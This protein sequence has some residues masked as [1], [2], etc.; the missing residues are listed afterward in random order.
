MEN[1]EQ[2][3]TRGFV[4]KHMI[5]FGLPLLAANLM[6]YLYQATDMIVVGQTMGNAGVVAISNASMIAFV[7]GSIAIGLSGGGTV[8]I[9]RCK[10]AGDP[11]GQ[12]SAS[13]ALFVICLIA[14]AVVALFGIAFAAPL[15]EALRV[16]A[17][18][19]ADA[20]AYMAI[21]C[22]GAIFTF[23]YNASCA[24]MKGLGD[25]RGPFAFMAIA[26]VV[27]VALDVVFVVGLRWGVA[28]VA[29]ATVIAQSLSCVL[30]AAY[31]V[32]RYP[33]A[34]PSFRGQ[35]LLRKSFARVLEVGLPSTFQMAIVNVSY[36]LVTGMLNVYG[37]DV[38][39]A[40][41]VGLK[42]STF[43]GLPCWAI[44]QAVTA[45]ASQNSGAKNG[46]RMR[47]VVRSGLALSISVIVSIQ[48]LIQ[49]FASDFAVL[50]GATGAEAVE[51]A[52]LYLRI[53]C[54]INGVF[55][56][57]MYCFDSFALGS[58]AP[59]LAFVN[60]LL[61]AVTIRFGLAWL[62]SVVFGFGFVGV[63]VAQAASPVLPTLIGLLYYRRG[64]WR[65]LME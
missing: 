40:A 23:G 2:D 7:V 44:G 38:A 42:I 28:G 54:S 6:Q 14:A 33:T 5:S 16:P 18:S 13:A 4:S 34:R 63:F 41:G 9:A 47:A 57:A 26:S 35:A 39:A 65:R 62:L 60:A 21:V 25:A 3:F 30:S 10:G 15:F 48:V 12:R 49:V 27:N 59:N 17:E 24:L 31:L 58:G 53:T 64:G 1:R 11:A 19:L 61:D 45:M 56:A 22:G 32:R 37:T 36:L 55:Y 52:V 50:F 46:M 43:A 8:V 51:V 29:W 20:A